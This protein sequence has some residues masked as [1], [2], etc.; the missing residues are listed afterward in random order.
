MQL[1]DRGTI[2]RINGMLAFGLDYMSGFRVTESY[3]DARSQ[4]RHNG[5]KVSI[6]LEFISQSQQNKSFPPPYLSFCLIYSVMATNLTF[7]CRAE[8][9]LVNIYCK[10][11][12]SFG[13][14]FKMIAD[15]VNYLRE[16]D[17]IKISK[18]GVKFPAGI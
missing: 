18:S 14:S 11:F 13:S 15:Q 5:R 8:T 2:V 9:K 7:L 17:I 6:V 16:T 10:H 12:Y 1:Q 3:T 4:Q